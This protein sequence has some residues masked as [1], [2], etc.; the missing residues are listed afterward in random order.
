VSKAD[1]A[2]EYR[3]YVDQFPKGKYLSDAWRRIGALEGPI[4]SVRIGK[5]FALAKTEVTQGQWKAVMGS[6]PSNFS[7]CGDNCSVENVSWSDAQDY[8]RKLSQ[9]TGKTYRLPSEAEWEYACRAGGTHTYCGSNDVDSVAWYKENSGL[10][11]NFVAGKQPNAWGLYDMSG[12]VWE[13]TEDC[14]HTAYSGAPGDGSAWTSGCN[15]D[16]RV[17][18]GGSWFSSQQVK[19][20]AASRG[21]S[22]T[23]VRDSDNG[24]R[25][26]RMLPS[27]Q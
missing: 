12:N 2:E 17:L 15:Q 23:M 3:L 19:K 20:E 9:K 24:F 10:K 14:Y 4:H 11:I 25:P 6:N 26:A 27:Y 5:A 13:W 18:R 22:S 21:V 8:M 16:R 1:V 7:S